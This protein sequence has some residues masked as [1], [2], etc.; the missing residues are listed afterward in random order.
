MLNIQLFSCVQMSGN[1]V[2]LAL[3]F[4]NPGG[5]ISLS[6]THIT[7]R[8]NELSTANGISLLNPRMTMAH[9]RVWTNSP[10]SSIDDRCF[11]VCPT[12]M[13]AD[14]AVG[15]SRSEERRVG[16]ECVSTCRSRWS[17]YH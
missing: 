4:K 14:L 2:C 15:V 11:T 1:F 8:T 7:K 17:P 3:Y 10:A 13:T 12:I 16:K 6:L 9:G 5:L